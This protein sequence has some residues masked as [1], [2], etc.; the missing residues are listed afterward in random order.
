MSQELTLVSVEVPRYL[1]RNFETLQDLEDFIN[2]TAL[3]YR[4]LSI[5]DTMDDYVVLLERRDL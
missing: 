3:A 1:V 5:S 4:P 2:E